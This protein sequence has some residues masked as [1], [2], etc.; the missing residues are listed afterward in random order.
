M[1]KR[2][3]PD[4]SILD[5]IT[6]IREPVELLSRF[7]IKAVEAAAYRGV[8][9][10]FA[11]FDQLQAANEANSETWRPMTTSFRS[12]IGGA[13]DDNGLVVFG[14]DSQ[15]DVVATQA[16]RLFDWQDTNFKTEA[17]SLRFFYADPDRSKQPGEACIVTAPDAHEIT[18][19]VMLSGA[20][21]YRPDYR[22][23]GLANIIPRFIRTCSYLRW[24]FNEFFAIVTAE[25]VS[26]SLGQRTGLRP[27]TK[28]VIL[29]NHPTIPDGDL[30]TML[31]RLSCEQLIADIATFVADFKVE[32]D[33]RVDSRRA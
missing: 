10:E 3:E 11:T 20:I 33:A 9:L 22:G 16:T 7:F 17:E 6:V 24:E 15:G 21:W 32:P 28:S 13:N 8:T 29:R 5:E 12:D 4:H 18:G 25:N 30:E 31:T 14:R 23:T 1:L 19:P 27:P 26:K 2:F